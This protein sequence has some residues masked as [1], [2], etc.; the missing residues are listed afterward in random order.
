MMEKS[1]LYSLHSHRLVEGVM[2]DPE[3]FQP[4][5]R[6][7][8]GKVRIWKVLGVD[9]DSKAWVADPANRV[10]DPPGS[11]QC[12]GQY[13]P[14]IQAMDSFQSKKAFAQREDFNVK[15]DADAEQ[16]TREYMAK[17]G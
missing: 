2:V 9:E 8:Y 17:M 1:F 5:Y 14:A 10:C 3:K 13:P 6:S 7:K 16:Y 11:W 15:K 12:A 4:V